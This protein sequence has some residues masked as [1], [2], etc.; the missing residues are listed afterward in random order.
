MYA[1]T[2][3]MPYCATCVCSPLH[4]R[5]NATYAQLCM[6]YTFFYISILI[7]SMFQSIFFGW[8]IFR[9]QFIIRILIRSQLIGFCIIDTHSNFGSYHPM[10]RWAS[11][12]LLG[13][14]LNLY[15]HLLIGIAIHTVFFNRLL[16]M[17]LLYVLRFW[18]HDH[19]VVSIIQLQLTDKILLHN[20]AY[21]ASHLIIVEQKDADIL[22]PKAVQW[23]WQNWK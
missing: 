6:R 8:K 2:H 21:C 13:C 1:R 12:Q 4:T 19:F 23:K 22:M 9:T 11:M 7:I 5:A 20:C 18:H 17:W 15:K 16:S 14:S 10:W 3:A